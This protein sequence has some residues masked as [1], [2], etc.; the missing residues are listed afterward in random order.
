MTAINVITHADAIH[1]LTD[2]E[3][4]SLEG[5]KANVGKVHLLPHINAA[6]SLNGPALALGIMATQ[7]SQAATFDEMKPLVAPTLQAVIKHFSGV[8]WDLEGQE[9]QMSV[10]VA[11]WSESSG[12][13][14]AYVVANHGEYAGCQP[15]EMTRLGDLSVSP[16]D[17]EAMERFWKEAFARN[18]AIE[19]PAD[20]D[21]VEDGGLLV[22]TQR[23]AKLGI[24]MHPNATGVGGFAQLTTIRKGEI[25]TRIIRDW[26]GE[27]RNAA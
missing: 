5:P 24:G 2:G 3:I 18:P 14:E 23:T 22:E 19:T 15:F 21:P 25:S 11:G 17:P 12:Q 1:L 4:F 8:W 7:M 27:R 26:R 16:N 9:T 10:V 6:I 13:P 20:L